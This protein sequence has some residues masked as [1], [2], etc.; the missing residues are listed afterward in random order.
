MVPSK[1]E[2]VVDWDRPKNA[3]EVKHFLGWVSYYRSCI[4]GFLEFAL[5]MTRLT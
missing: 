3:S 2:A 5:P 1:I 4:Q